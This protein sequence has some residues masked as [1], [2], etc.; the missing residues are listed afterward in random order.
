MTNVMHLL[1]HQEYQYVF[2]K[3]ILFLRN[4]LE[5]SFLIFVLFFL[6]IFTTCCVII[7]AKK[8]FR[9]GSHSK[10][11]IWIYDVRANMTY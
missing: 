2:V 9:C 1:L 8:Q 5:V 3:L 4:N 6:L 7:R 10:E 11:M